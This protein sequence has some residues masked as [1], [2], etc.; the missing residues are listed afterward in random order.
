MLL[1]NTLTQPD[2]GLRNFPSPAAAA[3]LAAVRPLRLLLRAQQRVAL[4]LLLLLF[5]NYIRMLLVSAHVHTRVCAIIL[6]INM[7]LFLVMDICLSHNLIPIELREIIKK[8]L[9]STATNC[10]EGLR[11]ATYDWCMTRDTAL[12][13][14]G[15]I[16]YWK[17]DDV[18]D[19]SN[20]FCS[21][22]DIPERSAFNDSLD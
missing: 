3:A 9:Y 19:M 20:L 7:S 2:L 6:Q 10:N 12:K 1:L 22:L 15:P 21:K 14:Y 4:S 5:F 8:Y 11:Q 17:T 18:T 16:S 13:L